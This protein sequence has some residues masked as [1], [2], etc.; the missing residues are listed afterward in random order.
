MICVLVAF[1]IRYICYEAAHCIIKTWPRFDFLLNMWPRGVNIA[2]T[3]LRMITTGTMTWCM[4]PGER[5]GDVKRAGYGNG[6][7][8]RDYVDKWYW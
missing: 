4:V 6:N 2:L 3:K 7:A 8:N 5:E 1:V